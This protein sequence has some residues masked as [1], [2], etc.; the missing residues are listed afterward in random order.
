MFKTEEEFN[1]HMDLVF[2]RYYTAIIGISSQLT[3][4]QSVVKGDDRE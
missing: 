2:N 4:E 1:E 3:V